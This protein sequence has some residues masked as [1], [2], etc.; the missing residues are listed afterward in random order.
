MERVFDNNLAYNHYTWL[1][2]TDNKNAFHVP[3]LRNVVIGNVLNAV[4]ILVIYLKLTFDTCKMS[5]K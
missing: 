4:N 2:R 5:G 1:G 3:T